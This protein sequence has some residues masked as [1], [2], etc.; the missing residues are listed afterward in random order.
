MLEQLKEVPVY[1]YKLDENI[2]IVR[3][4][5]GTQYRN[6]LNELPF[7]EKRKIGL[8][9][10]LSWHFLEMERLGLAE[11][12]ERRLN[13]KKVNLFYHNLN[14]FYQTGFDCAAI[15]TSILKQKSPLSSHLSPE[16][17][18]AV[19]IAG[20]KHDIGMITG[21]PILETVQKHGIAFN[22]TYTYPSLAHHTPI[23]VDA[24]MEHT[25]T[26]LSTV[27]FPTFLNNQKV[28]E[29]AVQGIHN[30]HFP[31]TPERTKERQLMLSETTPEQW[32]EAMI[33]RLVV[34][35]ADLGGQSARID[36]F[37][38]GLIALRDEMNS[39]QPGLGTTI[40]GKDA[41]LLEKNKA[42]YLYVIKPSVGKTA[43]AFFG[44]NNTYNKRWESPFTNQTGT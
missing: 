14:H 15:A 16:G 11:I 17:A 7:N 3:R 29:L 44:K 37:P 34:Q 5:F 25:R 4:A 33:V 26:T 22:N 13:P 30:T 40:I 32:K 27:P 35:L 19:A 18:L 36:Q 9:R 39:A 24:S 6:L 12:K 41:E 8:F 1:P 31:W 38:K 43:N 23:H 10:I 2:T 42:F 21:S 28:I 20:I